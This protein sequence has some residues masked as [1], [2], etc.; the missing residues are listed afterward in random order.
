[1]QEYLLWI[2]IALGIWL[3][4]RPFLIWYWKID[5]MIHL[6]EMIVASQQNHP[7]GPDWK[8][9]QCGEKNPAGVIKCLACGTEKA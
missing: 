7:T 5:R 8:C 3:L 9:G 1:M 2:V 4:L 6:L